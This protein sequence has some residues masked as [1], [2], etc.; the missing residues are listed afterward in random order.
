MKL[1]KWIAIFIVM[2]FLCGILLTG[3]SNPLAY[4][5]DFFDKK[6]DS[7]VSEN[8]PSLDTQENMSD[9]SVEQPANSRATVMYYKDGEN[10]L[11]PVMRY[12][13]KDELGIAKA[14]ISS[15]IY[16]TELAE[17]LKPTG[18]SPT[19][20]MGTKINGAVIKDSG[21][22]IIDF[23]SEF[24]N[25][26]TAEAEALGVKAVVYTLTEFPNITS[27]QIKVDGKAVGQLPKGTEIGAELKREE[28]NL[29]ASENNGDKLSKVMVYYQKKGSGDYSYYVP[30]TKLVTGTN[31]A[32]AAMNALIEGASAETGL[33]NPF[34]EATK[35]LG[36]QVK[37]GIAYVNFSEDI[38]AATTSKVAENSII[39]SVTL[40]LKDLPEISKVKLFVNGATIDS[41]EG[42]GADSYIDVPA[43]VNYYE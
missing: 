14:A 4:V 33:L 13:P 5:R 29:Q 41:T 34:P 18:L 24:A 1:K 32:E 15:L 35:L 9:V 42:I 21:L 39:K 11:V 12:V 19:L 23:S 3:C 43:F 37:D 36:V 6:K 8:L 30:V 31:R 25:F 20:P 17:N 28:I 16:S 38:L 2:I 27:V 10:L 22:A 26:T 40:T 7:P